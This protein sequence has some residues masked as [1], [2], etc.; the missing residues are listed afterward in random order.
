MQG[1][2]PQIRVVDQGHAPMS[3]AD[4]AAKLTDMATDP[5][6]HGLD[7]DDSDEPRELDARENDGIHVRLLWHSIANAI[8]VAVMDTRTGDRFEVAVEAKHAL[9]AFH[10]PFAFAA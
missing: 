7:L 2:P 1:P 4:R 5:H 6:H 10:H 3:G 9:R 8:T